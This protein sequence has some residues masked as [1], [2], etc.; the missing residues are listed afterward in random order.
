MSNS[1]QTTFDLPVVTTPRAAADV[2]AS[3]GGV[4]RM[5]PAW[6]PR[7]F[8]TPGRRLR[9]HPDDYYPFDKGRGGIDERWI[10]SAIRAD[11]GPTTGPFEGL[12]L[13]VSADGDALIPF[14]LIIE[15]GQSE[16]IGERLWSEYGA[17]PTFAKFFDNLMPLPFHI[18][19]SDEKA[20]AVGKRGK[21]E[22]YYYPPQMNNHLG[23]QPVSYLGLRPNVSRKEL[24]DHLKKHTAGGDN[25]ITNLSLGYRTRLG[26]GWDIPAGVLHAPASVCTYEPQ[27]ASDVLSMFES[28]SN[29]AEVGDDLLWKD[30]PTADRGNYEA[31][32]DIVDWTANSDPQFSE[33]RALVPY[34]TDASRAAGGGDYVEKWIVYKSPNFSAKEL[35]VFPGCS[36]TMAEQDAYGLIAVQGHGTINGQELA[37]ITMARINELTRDEYFVTAKAAQ[38][39]VTIVNTSDCEPLVVLKNFGPGNVE[40]GL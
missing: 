9:L 5:A 22:A 32:L 3:S 30:L 2:L 15:T 31:L 8:C 25:N 33:H 20:S 27:A 1:R 7:E 14:D 16:V 24:I 6:V 36:V 35:T 21:P 17:W 11:N 26:Q 23:E 38:A 12:S 40:L 19:A 37:A 10:A 4:L 34:E 28:W 39:G 13:A 29:N 18:H